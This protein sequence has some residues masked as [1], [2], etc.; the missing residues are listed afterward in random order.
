LLLCVAL[1]SLPAGG[2]PLNPS[3]LLTDMCATSSGV[4]VMGPTT[5]SIGPP[6]TDDGAGLWFYS[7]SGT[8]IN[9]FSVVQSSTVNLACFTVPVRSM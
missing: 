4:L 9:S 7:Q 2:W 8:L 3:P 5:Q 6:S 1:V